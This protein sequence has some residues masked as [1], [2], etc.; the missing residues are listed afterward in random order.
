MDIKKELRSEMAHGVT[1][2]QAK[3]IV[4]ERLEQKM[5]AIDVA[6]DAAKIIDDMAELNKIYTL[7]V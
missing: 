6:A 5:M 3:E 7:T 4:I 1:F 2:E